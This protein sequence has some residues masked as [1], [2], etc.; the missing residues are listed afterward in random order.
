[1]LR[2][3]AVRATEDAACAVAAGRD[4]LAD[5]LADAV[6]RAGEHTAQCVDDD[7]SSLYDDFAWNVREPNAG[8]PRS[9]PNHVYG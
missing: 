4:M 8:S 6:L 1:M 3:H 2:T 9:S 5:D 7:L